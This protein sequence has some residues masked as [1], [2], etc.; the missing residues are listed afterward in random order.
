[1]QTRTS[2]TI[3]TFRNP[4]SIGSAI[5]D[6]PAGSYRSFREEELIE[7]AS[8]AAYRAVSTTLQLPA[9][10]IPSMSKQYVSISTAELQAALDADIRSTKAKSEIRDES[11]SMADRARNYSPPR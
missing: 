7:A 4:F 10:G 6:Q 8:F 9:I 1:M 5:V 3:I 11:L 2:E